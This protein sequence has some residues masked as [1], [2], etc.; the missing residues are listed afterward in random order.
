[1][2]KSEVIAFFIVILY[3]VLA[4]YLYP[5]M[6]EKMASH[7]NVE[8]RV[9][10]YL[11]KSLALF[12]IPIISFFLF[13]LFLT[14][15]RIDPLKKNI[16]KFRNYF[17]AFFILIL[18]FLF[19]LYS[20]T[21]LWNLGLEFNIIKNLVPAFSVLFFYTGVLV[22]NAKRNWFIGIRTPWTLSSE[23]V[24]D[25]THK[26]A[27]KLIK[28]ASLITLF[29]F[30]FESFAFYFLILPVLFACFYSV[31]YSYFEFRKLIRK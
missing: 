3:F 18:L 4:F 14:I 2:R 15:P 8:G 28:I 29:G 5:Q 21:I 19:Y 25:K 9:D 17:D 10:G 7:W 16:E 11:P 20:L 13:L 27:G 23:K 30:F 12:L 24:W 22:E 31:V 1:M 26:L 6:P